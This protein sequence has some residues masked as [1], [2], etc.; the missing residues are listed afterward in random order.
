MK[1]NLL[2]VRLFPWVLIPLFLAGC[3]GKTAPIPEYS[4]HTEQQQIYLQS[5]LID[6]TQAGIDGCD[7]KSKP[8]DVLLTIPDSSK[9]SKGD[10]TTYT[11]RLSEDERLSS[12]EEFVGKEDVFHL[13]NLKV[14]TT[15]HYSYSVNGNGKVYSSGI[16][17]FRI[18][19]NAPRNMDI[20]GVTNARDVGGWRTIDG[21]EIVQGLIYRTGAWH[22]ETY[23]YISESGKEEVRRLGIKTEIDLRKLDENEVLHS[24]VDG[25]NYFSFP[26][27]ADLD[28][29]KEPMNVESTKAVF[30]LFAKKEAYPIAFHCYIGTD[31]TGFIAFL[32]GAL[33]GLSEDDLV[34]DYVFSNFGNIEGTRNGSTIRNRVKILKKDYDGSSDIAIGAENFLKNDVGISKEKLNVIRDIML[35]RTNPFA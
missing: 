23:D 13:K 4:I 24:A 27:N 5:R 32:L 35:G 19:D 25:V 30:E 8:L 22:Q 20:D 18:K 1:G 7:E 34:R 6:D 12:Y 14:H 16:E 28:L 2:K 29:F 15:Y 21:D 33:L 31:R 17:S 10:K 9:Y 26:M 3:S 11:L